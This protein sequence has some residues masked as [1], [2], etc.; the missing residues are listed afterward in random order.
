MTFDLEASKSS[1]YPSPCLLLM[2]MNQC[3]CVSTKVGDLVVALKWKAKE[4]EF[5]HHLFT[6]R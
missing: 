5:G 3:Q 6:S 1:V 4:Q 2:A